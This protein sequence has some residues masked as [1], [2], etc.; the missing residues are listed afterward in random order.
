MLSCKKPNKLPCTKLATIADVYSWILMASST[1]MQLHRAPSTHHSI[2][3]HTPYT[4]IPIR[5]FLLLIH[6]PS[7]RK[8]KRATKK[9]PTPAE[10]SKGAFRFPLRAIECLPARLPSTGRRHRHRRRESSGR[11]CWHGSNGT[12]REVRRGKSID[13]GS[14]IP[15]SLLLLGTAYNDGL[16]FIS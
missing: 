9:N 7:P 3:R 12:S 2:A 15:Q 6:D 10:S 16:A 5:L 11:P 8:R 13:D 4:D 14:E 1:M